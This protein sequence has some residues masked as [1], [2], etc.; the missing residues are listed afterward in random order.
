MQYKVDHTVGEYFKKEK[1]AGRIP[2]ISDV[3]EM[4]KKTAEIES[5]KKLTGVE[6]ETK[7]EQQDKEVEVPRPS[8]DH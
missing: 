8:F 4:V 6:T 2:K 1:D 7:A 3:Q 5:K